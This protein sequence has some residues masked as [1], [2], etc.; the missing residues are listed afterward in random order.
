MS[1]LLVLNLIREG[2][3]KCDFKNNLELITTQYISSKLNFKRNTISHYL[4]E[5]FAND[6]VIK[7][8]SRPVYYVHREEFEKRYFKLQRNEYRDIHELFYRMD[9]NKK[10]N[11]DGL[12]DVIGA[13]NSLKD[14][15]EQMKSAVMYPPKG[16]PL[17]LLGKSG[18]GK[19]YFANLLYKYAIEMSVLE[20]G[21]P[22]EIFNCAQYYNNPELLSANLFGYAKGAFTGANESK[23]GLLEKCNGGI[24]FLDEVHRLS[25]EGQEKLFIFLDKGVYKR[26]GDN[27]ERRSDVRFIF[28]TTEEK[29][30]IFLTTF[31]RRI[32]IQLYIPS[33]KER[34]EIERKEFVYEF[35]IEQARILNKNI[36]IS[37]LAFN[38]LADAEYSGNIGELLNTIKRLVAAA[39]QKNIK[40]EIISISYIDLP[41]E[42]IISEKFDKIIAEYP[43]EI[44]ITPSKKVTDFIKRDQIRRNEIYCFQKEIEEK[45]R[46][47]I[48]NESSDTAFLGSIRASINSLLDKV[49]YNDGNNF[50]SELIKENI[51]N[52]LR[53]IENNNDIKIR[54]DSVHS[55]TY[56]INYKIS[57]PKGYF[58]DADK[59]KYLDSLRICFKEAASLVNKIE[60]LLR[61]RIDYVFDEDDKIFFILYFAMIGVDN[62]EGRI[63][64]II[65]THGYST[66]SSIANVAN[67]LLEEKIFDSIDMSIDMSTSEMIEILQ[68]YIYSHN[69]AS[70]LII[71]VD[72]GSLNEINERLEFNS[73]VTIGIINNVTTQMALDIGIKIIQKL[74]MKKILAEAVESNKTSYKL[75]K[76]KEK[77]KAII[78]TCLSGIGTAVKI[79]DLL[80]KSIPE[81]LNIQVIPCEYNRLNINGIKDEI[82]DYYNVLSIIGTDNPNIPNIE[83]VSLESIISGKEKNILKRVLMDLYDDEVL[84]EINSNLVRN[85][86]LDSVIGS[87][88]ILDSEKILTHIEEATLNLE[89]YLKI[90]FTNEVKITFFI[91]I[92]CMIERLIRQAPIKGYDGIDTLVNENS[93]FIDKFKASFSGIEKQYCIQIPVSEIGYIFDIVRI[94]MPDFKC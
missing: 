37:R 15:I 46:A 13:D 66:A 27:E 33:L 79:K 17:L 78:T 54:G 11:K 35:L 89:R 57:N 12:D 21:A 26:I 52:I 59:K 65:L 32:P 86:S 61:F 28:A 75:I 73:D 94:K 19:S 29:N 92:S 9:D 49:I 88:T 1:K 51:K 81:K 63:K 8:N 84:S 58:K 25:P 24:L 71:L 77:S 72:M 91:H 5:L 6:E 41:K 4:N 93:K 39:Y 53:V 82:F 36:H 30:N 2:T 83:Y 76:L 18:V 56:Y 42:L 50:K 20:S 40:S 85:F 23:A 47:F 87:L 14:V 68:E 70:G 38:A 69:I 67:R 16:L 62:V 10:E 55:I 45:L 31:L 60:K 3:I 74:E 80:E 64:A 48:R 7:I 90:K 22:L 43:E 34:T 44:I